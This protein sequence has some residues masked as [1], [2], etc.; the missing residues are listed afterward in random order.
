MAVRPPIRI[1][2]ENRFPIIVLHQIAIRLIRQVAPVGGRCA[3]SAALMAACVG[4]PE[5]YCVGAVAMC[6]NVRINGTWGWGGERWDCEE[7][8]W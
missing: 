1:A 5:D 8:S 4:C 2:L 7:E 3:V 6:G